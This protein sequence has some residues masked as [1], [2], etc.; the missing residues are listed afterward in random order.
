MP[1]QSITEAVTPRLDDGRPS[2]GEKLTL[3]TSEAAAARSVRI[4]EK[5]ARE[6][7]ARRASSHLPAQ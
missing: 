5:S 2:C 1:C 7:H 4:G 3:A 6:A